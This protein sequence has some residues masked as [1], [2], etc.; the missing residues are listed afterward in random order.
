MHLAFQASCISVLSFSAVPYQ[1]KIRIPDP[2]TMPKK[3][4]TAD[5]PET[6]EKKTVKKAATKTEPKPKAAKKSDDTKTTKPSTTKKTAA[7]EPKPAKTAKPRKTAP[8]APEPAVEISEEHIRVAAYYRWVDRGMTH[9][10]H[11]DDWCE[12]EKQIKG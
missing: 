7:A 9:G 2:N 8:A 10:C 12:A 11:E 3:T 5:T 1:K 4:T 6:Q